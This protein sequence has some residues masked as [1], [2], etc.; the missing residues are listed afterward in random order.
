MKLS[1][2]LNDGSSYAVQAYEAGIIQINN[3]RH[4]DTLVVMPDAVHTRFANLTQVDTLTEG[5]FSELAELGAELI[6]VGT[7]SAQ[8]FLHP[9]LWAHLSQRGIGV[10]FMD[11]AAA[12]RTYNIL[13]SEGRRVA[14]LLFPIT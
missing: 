6:I 10:E 2:E 11:T 3:T 12:C 13:M 4:T 14:A 1:L 9:R 7:G 8:Q 5:E